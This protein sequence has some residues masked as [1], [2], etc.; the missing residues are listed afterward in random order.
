MN[1]Y[2]V[3]KVTGKNVSYF[4]RE[5]LKRNINIYNLK[6]SPHELIITINKDDYEKII[7]IKTSYK[8]VLLDRLGFHK[9]YYLLKNNLI[10]LIFFLLS[11]LFI[12]LLSNIIFSIDINHSNK[13]I[14]ALIKND[15]N[16]YGI[17]K[18]H[19]KKTYA[20]QEQITQKI[21]QKET[22]DLEWLEIKRIGTK[23]V[24]QVEQRK[25]NKLKE[26]CLAQN[27]I[28]SKDARVLEIQAISGEVK[29]KKNDYVQK[30]NVLISGLIYNKETI[31]AKRCA[32][33]NVYGEV[34]YKVN[35]S[36]PKNYQEETLTGKSS[37]GLEI[38]FFNYN[39]N[40]FNK[41][42]T[43]KK[44]R[45]SLIYNQILPIS[46]NFTKFSETNILSKKYT[47]SNVEKEALVIAEK[48]LLTQLKKDATILSK[49]VLKKEQNNSKINVE[50]FL[51]VK[52]NI[53]AYQ[54][55]SKIN[56]EELNEKE[57]K[58]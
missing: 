8:I 30:G 29:V 17:K 39:F 5:L 11:I 41:Y 56:I 1:N 31:V 28:A 54:D 43:S 19:L 23:Y 20:Q 35:I 55:I 3:I 33:G 25:K 32:Q 48:R 42:K 24:I 40:L 58:E 46:L 7:S 47:V 16:Y 21:L 44:K 15:L 38:T 52:E 12:Y 27:I 49:K 22:N 37:Y 51:K 2:Y 50:V 10:F 34:W 45:Y 14:I 6:T 13:E 4:L 57:Q 9:Y 36:L 53:T 26:K 18:Y